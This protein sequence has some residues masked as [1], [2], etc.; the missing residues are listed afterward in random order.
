MDALA[1]SQEESLIE[2]QRVID[3]QGQYVDSLRVAL[4]LVLQGRAIDGVL[5]PE[6]GG[7]LPAAETPGVSVAEIIR[8]TNRRYSLR[9]HLRAADDLNVVVARDRVTAA[10]AQL[11][12]P[13]TALAYG[14]IGQVPTSFVYGVIPPYSTYL[15]PDTTLEYKPLLDVH[16]A[17]STV[18][19]PSSPRGPGQWLTYHGCGEPAR[20]EYESFAEIMTRLIIATWVVHR[21]PDYGSGEGL[22]LAL[23]RYL[24]EHQWSR[25]S[26]RLF[27]ACIASP[28]PRP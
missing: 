12:L 18:E 27:V 17:G 11:F 9:L 22:A 15:S 20:L 2:L 4:D 26:T 21:F 10:L 8:D 6:P 1:G 24:R 19:L 13:R 3:A 25:T 23:T 14:H 7:T 5:C 28:C 16:V